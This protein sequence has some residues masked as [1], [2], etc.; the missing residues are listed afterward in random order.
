MRRLRRDRLTLIAMAIIVFLV[1]ISI[2]WRGYSM[3]AR[4]RWE[5]R[6]SRH[7]CQSGLV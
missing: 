3:Q 5:S 6:S 7:F 2:T 1:G 4:Y